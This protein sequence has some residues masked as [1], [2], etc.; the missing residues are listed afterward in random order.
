MRRSTRWIRTSRPS[1]EKS[2]ID[3]GV[4][5]LTSSYDDEQRTSLSPMSPL[6]PVPELAH[7]GT[8]VFFLWEKRFSFFTFDRAVHPTSIASHLPFPYIF[9]AIQ[10]SFAALHTKRTDVSKRHSTENV[11]SVTS[12]PSPFCF[13]DGDTARRGTVAH[14]EPVSNCA[15]QV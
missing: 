11:V 1:C 4:P 15:T 8:G 2:W 13:P 10:P 12:I 14:R 9:P 6:T 3:R 7:S 5:F